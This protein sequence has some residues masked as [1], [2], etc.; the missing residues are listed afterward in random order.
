MQSE[1]CTECHIHGV[2]K[3]VRVKHREETVKPCTNKC[4]QS[5]LSGG[6][7]HQQPLRLYSFK[8]QCAFSSTDI[9]KAEAKDLLNIHPR[10]SDSKHLN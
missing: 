6:E 7:E 8:Q 9:G 2:F 10:S 5:L 1:N 3:E 4:E